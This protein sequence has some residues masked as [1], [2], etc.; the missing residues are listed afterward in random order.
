MEVPCCPSCQPSVPVPG[1]LHGMPGW[2]AGPQRPSQDRHTE[3]R[4]EFFQGEASLL[5]HIEPVE[6][7]LQLFLAAQEAELGRLQGRGEL[8]LFPLEKTLGRSPKKRGVYPQTPLPP[9]FPILESQPQADPAPIL[10]APGPHPRWPPQQGP[11][12]PPHLSPSSIQHQN[13]SVLSLIPLRS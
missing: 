8:A 1:T 10:E 6:D 5:L 7:Q 4:A 11:E 9:L 12:L 2:A 3:P 13:L